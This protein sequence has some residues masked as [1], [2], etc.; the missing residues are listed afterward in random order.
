M[1]NQPERS[2]V[3]FEINVARL[4][5][6]GMPVTIEADAAQRERLA[7]IHGLESVDRFRADLVAAAWKGSG[8][9]VQGTVEADIVQSCVVTLEPLPNEIREEI[10]A[11]F[12]PEDSKLLRPAFDSSELV[13]DAEGPDVPETYSGDTVDV[14]AL[15]EEIFGLAIDPYPRKP[16]AE[17]KGPGAAS[18]SEI[19][20]GPLQEQLRALRSK[21]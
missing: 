19:P 16:G 15:A 4:P 2:P 1:K 17:L 14:G 12:L 21:S 20:E 6:K 18:E 7:A 3:S 11:V 5:K 10:S 9:R 13:L 8:V